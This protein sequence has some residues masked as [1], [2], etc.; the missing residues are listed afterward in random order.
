MMR[1]G[2]LRLDLT[3]ADAADRVRGHTAAAVQAKLD[4]GLVQRLRDYA[5]RSSDGDE[6]A[7][8]ERIAELE[9]ESDIERVLEGNAA[10]LALT[11][12]VLAALHH[13]RWLCVPGLVTGF[14][15]QHALQGWC[16][17]V[18]VFRRLGIRTRKE[19]A[20]ERYALKYLRGDFRSVSEDGG[21]DPGALLA[22]AVRR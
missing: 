7:L 4:H 20:A 22:S 12:T 15:L 17:P 18:A 6:A 3:E 10:A 14:L 11:G 5:N 9:Q 16:P 1:N 21:S 2:S 8:S 19:I 13:R